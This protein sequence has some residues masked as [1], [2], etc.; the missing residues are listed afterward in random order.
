M[1]IMDTIRNDISYVEYKD[2]MNRLKDMK[3]NG[4]QNKEEFTTLLILA[5]M[6]WKSVRIIKERKEK[7]WQQQNT[8]MLKRY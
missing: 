1:N 7:V 3:E 6:A 4:N 5:K 8:A 2:Y